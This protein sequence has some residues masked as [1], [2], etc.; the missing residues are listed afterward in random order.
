MD[1]FTVIALIEGGFAL[2]Q[3]VLQVLDNHQARQQGDASGTSERG[4]QAADLNA[5]QRALALS[6]DSAASYLAERI[7]E[8]ALAIVSKL[9]SDKL[10]ELRS[11]ISNTALVL[12]MERA[13]DSLAYTLSLKESAD[14]ARNRVREGK[15]QWFGPW[16]TAEALFAALLSATPSSSANHASALAEVLRESR[17][18][19]LDLTI[20]HLVNSNRPIPWDTVSLFLSGAEVGTLLKLLPPPVRQGTGDTQETPPATQRTASR[21]GLLECFNCRR[22]YSG[23]GT[24]SCPGCGRNNC[25]NRKSAI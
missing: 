13:N 20:P 8:V 5:L 9:E 17:H 22:V 1:P 18:R 25:D 7:A 6:V 4:A 12:R 14:Y 23:S 10:E 24:S 16:L 3:G 15:I 19:I 2:A 21:S 11:R